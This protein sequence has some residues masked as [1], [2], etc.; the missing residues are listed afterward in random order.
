M[1]VA[2][3]YIDAASLVGVAMVAGSAT[4]LAVL[5][6]RLAVA[7]LGAHL[8][9]VP[10]AMLLLGA[11]LG[12][13][14]VALWPGAT[15]AQLPHA[16]LATAAGLAALTSSGAVFLLLRTKAPDR[17]DA[18]ALS[19]LAPFVL[20]GSLPFAFSGAAVFG[21]LAR[22]PRGPARAW[23]ATLLGAALGCAAALALLPLGPGRGATVLGIAQGLGA[24][25]FAIGGA[26][27]ARR[28][29]EL[30]RTGGWVAA[31]CF[32]SSISVLLGDVGAPYLRLPNLRSVQP[33]RTAYLG[34]SELGLV[35]VDKPARGTTTL[36]TDATR[37][38]TIV[39]ATSDRA[40]G[41]DDLVHAI[42]PPAAP[43]FVAAAGGGRELRAALDSGRSEVIAVEPDRRVAREVMLGA[44]REYTGGLYVRPEVKLFVGDPRTVLR[45]RPERHG[46]IVIALADAWAEANLGR[47]AS[48]PEPLFTLEAFG[49]YLGAL[50]DDGALF[51][52]RSDQEMERLLSTVGAALRGAGARDPVD[53]VYACSYQRS[54]GLV[55]TKTA[56]G[57]ERL[58]VLRSHCKKNR[59]P[60]ILAPDKDRAPRRAALLRDPASARALSFERDATPV[61]DDRP[62]YAYTVPAHRFEETARDRARLASEQQGLGVVLALFALGIVSALVV[63]LAPMLVRPKLLLT[64]TE[65]GPRARALAVSAA[66][67]AAASMALPALVQVY[68]TSLGHPARGAAVAAMCLYASAA[69]GA[70]LVRRVHPA[71][72]RRVAFRLA[73]GLAPLLALSALVAPGLRAELSAWPLLLKLALA[74]AVLGAAGVLY[75]SLLSLASFAIAA[76]ARSLAAWAWALLVAV[77]L[78][79]YALGTLL[80]LHVGYSFLLLVGAV[81]VYAAAGLLPSAPRPTVVAGPTA[82]PPGT[83]VR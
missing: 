58:R 46:V 5:L 39:E 79:G 13:S 69:L 81:C 68:G 47:M 29:G 41:L 74:A 36:R 3:P 53:H 75:G 10:Y 78:V 35:T 23:S 49:D 19:E 50:R 16:R 2:R 73:L 52:Q 45:T 63:L 83:L 70:H 54:T 30:A 4:G 72:A 27:A 6:E 65:R 48:R 40:K 31:A 42:A 82:A 34:W 80:A 77:A 8:G 14:T 37:A 17:L 60:E 26:R 9:S 64:A 55:V 38:M 22:A 44:M 20:V 61:T 43:V 67:G 25:C 28:T 15:R 21:F 11:A 66:L 7:L 62:F 59:Y 51:V 12:A 71:R 33:E 1:S 56:L 18:A 57:A 76:R 32:L 24:V